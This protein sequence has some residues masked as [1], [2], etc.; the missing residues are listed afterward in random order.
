MSK[1]LASWVKEKVYGPEKK[2]PKKM[3]KSD[4]IKKSASFVDG[5]TSK[6]AEL[7]KESVYK[8]PSPGKAKAN[9]VNKKSYNATKQEAPKSDTKASYM[10]WRKNY[11]A[12]RAKTKKYRTD[13]NT[14][15]GVRG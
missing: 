11:E 3:K 2:K 12:N 8:T 14:I 5:F 10:K 15:T 6:L 13:P 9:L 1:R 7:S 4:Y